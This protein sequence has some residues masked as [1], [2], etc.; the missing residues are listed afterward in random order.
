MARILAGCHGGLNLWAA[1][2]DAAQCVGLRGREAGPVRHCG[3]AQPVLNGRDDL[4]VFDDYLGRFSCMLFGSSAP[5][6]TDSDND[7]GANRRTRRA[8]HV[9]LCLGVPPPLKEED[10][11]GRS[12]ET[13]EV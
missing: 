6:R 10:F 1:F 12:A 3:T 5:T 9:E 7:R 13:V 4:L 8:R 2:L 11:G